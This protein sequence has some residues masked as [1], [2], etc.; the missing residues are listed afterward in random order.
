MSE[1]SLLTRQ[2]FVGTCCYLVLYHCQ[3]ISYKEMSIFNLYLSRENQLN[4]LEWQCTMQLHTFTP[5]SSTTVLFATEQLAVSVPCSLTTAVECRERFI[6]FLYP[7]ITP[8]LSEDPKQWPYDHKPA[9]LTSWLLL[10]TQW[11]HNKQNCTETMTSKK[12][13]VQNHA[14]CFMM[15]LGIVTDITLHTMLILYTLHLA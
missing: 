7:H 2:C 8:Q 10:A 1:L 5:G 15:L 9:S 13:E 6:H 12:A 4:M 11:W 14:K 3:V